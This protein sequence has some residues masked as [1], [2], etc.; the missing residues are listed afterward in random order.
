MILNNISQLNISTNCEALGG[1]GQTYLL[2]SRLKMYKL[3]CHCTYIKQLY[4]RTVRGEYGDW[5]DD[6]KVQT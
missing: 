6:L 2:D 1:S 3:Y 4:R 5:Y